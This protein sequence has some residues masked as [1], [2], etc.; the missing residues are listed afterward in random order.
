M[1]C[2][3]VLGLLA[4]F[5]LLLAQNAGPELAQV[6]NFEAT[7]EGHLPAG[8]SG[9]PPQTGPLETIWI[10]NKVVHGG[11]HSVRLER[12]ANSANEF[13]TVTKRIPLGL[14]GKQLELRG[15]LLT[16]TV[17][18][19]AGLWLRE[20]GE[21]GFIAF[22]NM[23]KRGLKGSADWKEY[24][25]ILP[26][27]PD[28]TQ[29]YF[30]V[31]LSGTGKAWADDL[32]LLI[33]GRSIWEA[34]KAEKLPTAL[35]LDHE[36]DGGS[37]VVLTDLTQLQVENLAVLGRV[38]GFLKYHHPRI[39][40]GEKHWDYELFRI[41]PAVLKAPDRAAA[42]AAILKWTQTFGPI[43]PCKTCASL[44]ETN[45][46]LHPALEWLKD[47]AKLGKELS[48]NLQSVYRNRFAGKKQFFVLMTEIGNPNF[49]HELG[50]G[51]AKLPD[52]G[53]QLLSVYRFWNIIEYWF[54]YR[55]VIGEDWDR[56]LL[57]SIPKV[58][59]AR[60]PSDYKREL[61]ALIA[62]VHDTHANLWSSISVRPPTGDCQIPVN[63]RFIEGK[64]VVTS[65]ASAESGPASGLKIGD[66]V[67]SVDGVPVSALVRNW[68][69]YYA[70]SNDAARSRD[71]ASQ[72]L[73]GSCGEVA[74]NV[75]RESGEFPIKTA[76]LAASGIRF[77]RTH[78]LSGDTFRLLSE[79]VA[80]LKLSSVKVADTAKYIESAAKTKGMVIDIRNYPSEFVVFALGSL[81]VEKQ[82]PFVTF[83]RGDPANPGAFGWESEPLSLRPAKP[84]Y[85]G[86]IVILVDEM[87]QS[88]A[89]YT[90]MAFRSV[91]GAVVV[92]STTAGADG[93]V[94]PISLPGGLRSMISG[95]GVFYPDKRPAQRVGIIPDQE[96]KP[97]IA[98]IRAGRDEVL[99][100]GIREI[101]GAE[102]T[103]DAIKNMA[104]HEH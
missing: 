75:S 15:F 28:A 100:A 63:V 1:L 36:F 9:G 56:V 33:D 82:T 93:N 49:T 38:W 96:I 34:P 98:G 46:Y 48:Q 76:R 64:A 32:Q 87:S 102:A 37:G 3:L 13:S 57:D 73:R 31:L 43:V 68:A 53:F 51:S 74:L 11:I 85:S 94:F 72:M 17:N 84:Y 99:E 47:E 44:V 62:E 5:V 83:T 45:L 19:F 23:E 24:S 29:L 86:R 80:Y 4:E 50:Y 54:P 8:W 101:V 27:D 42:N 6:L 12:T 22:D 65:Y 97:T 103:P 10:D 39:A 66:E 25:V 30:G 81:L 7:P 90:A 92:G 79:D 60:D 35:D 95:L 52:A 41:L 71:I 26:L 14:S 16:E 59:L 69:R 2:R 91:P 89:E 21:A 20:D 67:A 88:Q 55:D 40:T 58:A 104:R 77:E 61:M 70:A 18:G 78:D